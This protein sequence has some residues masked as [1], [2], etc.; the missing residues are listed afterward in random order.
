MALPMVATALTIFQTSSQVSPPAIQS[1]IQHPR[2]AIALIDRFEEHSLRSAPRAWKKILRD[3]T[4]DI[5]YDDELTVVPGDEEENPPDTMLIG[6]PLDSRHHTLSWGHRQPDGA[7]TPYNGPDVDDLITAYRLTGD[8]SKVEHAYRLAQATLHLG[9][10]SLRDGR[11][12]GC[13]SGRFAAGPGRASGFALAD[14]ALGYRDFCCTHRPKVLYRHDG[15]ILG[16]PEKI[17]ALCLPNGG[18]RT[19]QLYNNGQN[20]VSL[21]ICVE[22]TNQQIASVTLDGAPHSAFQNRTVTLDLQP[23]Q[24]HRIEIEL[25]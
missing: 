13:S 20:T 25:C 24:E 2:D 8:V 19:V 22:D 21:D 7:V 15:G 23:E 6:G 11:E 18:G 10:L 14:T 1:N 9:R 12:H 5:R 3:T 16:L 4:G 17:A